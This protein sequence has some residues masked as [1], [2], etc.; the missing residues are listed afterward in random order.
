M[1]LINQTKGLFQNPATR[2]WAII[3][4]T[5]DA[6]TILALIAAVA[7]RHF[8]FAAIIAIVYAIA[9]A[10]TKHYIQIHNAF[11]FGAEELDD[12]L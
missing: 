5:V 8:V 11:P 2:K 4:A 10:I 3:A 12:E 1:N 6:S 9:Y 7:S